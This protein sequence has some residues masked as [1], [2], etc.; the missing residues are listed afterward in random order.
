MLK[1]I[2]SHILFLLV[3]IVTIA[4]ENAA[5]A[6]FPER[7][8]LE[9]MSLRTAIIVNGITLLIVATFVYLIVRAAIG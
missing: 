1:R 7:K 4:S 2:A 6:W 3:F 5:Q 9:A 8:N